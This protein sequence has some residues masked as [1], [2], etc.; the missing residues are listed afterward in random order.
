[1]WWYASPACGFLPNRGDQREVALCAVVS[2]GLRPCRASSR[3]LRPHHHSGDGR[4][5]LLP[6]GRAARS[7]LHVIS[8]VVEEW[9]AIATEEITLPAS[10]QRVNSLPRQEGG[11]VVGEAHGAVGCSRTHIT[12]LTRVLSAPHL[13]LPLW[14]VRPPNATPD[15]GWLQG[16]AHNALVCSQPRA[17]VSNSAHTNIK[18]RRRLRTGEPGACRQ[19][20]L[21]RAHPVYCINC[22]AD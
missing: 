7:E 22:W 20:W 17:H 1:L 21:Q 12:A 15:P 10:V 4:F 3:R 9:R 5:S 19:R 14:V 6:A 2:S 16:L 13:Q 11:S 8:I 18:N